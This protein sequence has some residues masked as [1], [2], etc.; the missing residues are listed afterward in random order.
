MLTQSHITPLLID[1]A[2]SHMLDQLRIDSR[3]V[4]V[5]ICG[6]RPTLKTSHVTVDRR[7]TGKFYTKIPSQSQFGQSRSKTLEHQFWPKLAKVGL[8][9]VGQAHCWPK[10]VKELAKVAHDLLFLEWRTGCA[11]LV[12]GK[13]AFVAGRSPGRVIQKKEQNTFA[14]P[15]RHAPLRWPRIKGNSQ[16]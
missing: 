6:S 2:N 4:L 15:C 14:S 12:G 13:L 11:S 16:K 3:R 5:T 1:P 9:K 7:E 10:S 8:A